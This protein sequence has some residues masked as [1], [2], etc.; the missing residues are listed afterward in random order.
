MQKDRTHFQCSV[1]RINPTGAA[2]DTSEAM[3]IM[4]P[5]ILTGCVA[6]KPQ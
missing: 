1:Y 3:L 2:S 6:M 4:V 5:F